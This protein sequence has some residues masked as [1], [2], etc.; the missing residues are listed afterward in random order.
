ME[1]LTYLTGKNYSDW[2]VVMKDDEEKYVPVEDSY[3]AVA[4]LNDMKPKKDN[5]LFF[6]TLG[7]LGLASVISFRQQKRKPNS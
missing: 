3:A 2:D 4:S 6:A 5:T 1:M 7:L